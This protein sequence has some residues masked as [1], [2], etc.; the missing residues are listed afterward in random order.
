MVFYEI[1]A[2]MEI[3]KQLVHSATCYVLGSLVTGI[4]SGYK[5]PT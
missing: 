4:V 2:N 5:N 3:E 1:A